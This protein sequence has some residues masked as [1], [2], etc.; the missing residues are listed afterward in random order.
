[1]RA[2][3]RYVSNRAAVTPTSMFHRGFFLPMLPASRATSKIGVAEYQCEKPLRQ[4]VTSG[5]LCY[6]ESA[7]GRSIIVGSSA[8]IG[9]LTPCFKDYKARLLYDVYDTQQQ[10]DSSFDI[11]TLHNRPESVR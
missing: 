9:M 1:M 11:L 2:V 6:T 4:A 10:T 3:Q 5:N 7:R 8:R